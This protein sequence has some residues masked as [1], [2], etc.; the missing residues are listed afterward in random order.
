MITIKVENKE[1]TRGSTYIELI[2][3]MYDDSYI[4]LT[5]YNEIKMDVR[6]R[7]NGYGNLIY[8]AS[9]TDGTLTLSGDTI[10]RFEM[11]SDTT[12]DMSEGVY[13]R[14]LQLTDTWGNIFTPF[15][16]KIMV[17]ENITS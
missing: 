2:S 8:S 9:L 12:S 7:M 16:G 4:N 11:D 10:L 1:L 6:D 13:F 17:R 5:D 15:W 14:E 3:L